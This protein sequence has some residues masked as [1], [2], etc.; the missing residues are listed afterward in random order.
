M[1]VLTTNYFFYEYRSVIT[2]FHWKGNRKVKYNQVIQDHEI[3]GL[4]LIDLYSK[5]Q[6]MK[7]W[8]VNKPIKDDDGTSPIFHSLPIHNNLI[9][10]CNM[11][12]GDFKNLNKADLSY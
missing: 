1:P 7:I 11:H 10:Y 4:K 2:S 6:A 3:G 8:W 5:D 12:P 9:W